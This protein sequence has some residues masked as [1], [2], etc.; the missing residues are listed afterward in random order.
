VV[1]IQRDAAPAKVQKMLAYGARVV[2]VDGDMA[3]ASRVLGALLAR[4]RWLNCGGANPYRMTAKRLVA[5]EVTAQMA[6]AVPDAL[7]F[8]CG[9]CSGLVAA[10]Q[11]Y[12]ELLAMGL[13]PRM[14]RLIGVQL[15]AC[16]PVTRAYEE[17]RAE[18]RPAAKRPSFSDALMNNAPF[19]GA[20]A[21]RASRETGGLFLSV[22]DEEVAA[23][24]RALAAQEGLFVE[25]AGAVAVAGL[26]RLVA[27]GRA[28]GLQRVVCT[29]TGHG[30]NAPLAAYPDVELPPLVAPEAEAVETYLG[31][32]TRSQ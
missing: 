30:L 3:A 27:E 17:G 19:W 2:R 4:H 21:L 13:I 8:P 26:A 20:A 5:Y 9:G 14:P 10:H 11:G 7:L 12:R 16:D 24:I 29:L 1:C 23:M 31:K 25:P 15:A 28:A 6:G 18:I 22:T 32:M